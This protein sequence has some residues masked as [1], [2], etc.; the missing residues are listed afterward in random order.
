MKANSSIRQMLSTAA[1]AALLATRIALADG[2][3]VVEGVKSHA[4]EHLEVD[5]WKSDVAAKVCEVDTLTLLYGQGSQVDRDEAGQPVSC[6]KEKVAK[7]ANGTRVEEI[8]SSDSC[9]TRHP[10]GTFRRVRVVEGPNAG[11]SG[12]INSSALMRQDSP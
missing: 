8:A 5:L 12:C 4:G 1:L 11:K 10:P 7:L 9:N 2:G 6:A 3:F